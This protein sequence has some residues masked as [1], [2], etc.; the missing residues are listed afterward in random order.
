MHVITFFG[1]DFFALG[2]GLGIL[3]P[4]WIR[5]LS[6]KG[7]VVRILRLIGCMPPSPLRILR[8][9]RC[10]Q[11]QGPHCEDSQAHRLHAPFSPENPQGEEVHAA[12]RVSV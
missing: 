1:G 8:V 5:L 6:L 4:P 3:E 12:S 10:M 7:F 9:R 2:P 11:P